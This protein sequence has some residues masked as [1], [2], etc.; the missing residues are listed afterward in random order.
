MS[1]AG[2]IKLGTFIVIMAA[3]FAYVTQRKE[4][5]LLQRTISPD[6]VQKALAVVVVTLLT[7]A[8]ALLLLTIFEDIAFVRLMY[9]VLGAIS[10]TG[11]SQ[12]LTPQ[13]STPSH[14]V[15]IVLMFMGRVGPLTLVYSLTTRR[16]SRVRY[17]EMQFQVG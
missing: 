14:C 12:S 10:T 11:A 13:L 17:P 6:T 16:R 2:G 8:F 7:A 1:T 3:V 9:E 4:V 15:L 5:V